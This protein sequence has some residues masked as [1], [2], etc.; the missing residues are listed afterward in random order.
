LVLEI[1]VRARTRELKHLN[2]TLEEKVVARTNDLAAKIKDMEKFQRL[3]IGRELKMIELKNEIN[4]L[5]A[6]IAQMESTQN[7]NNGKNIQ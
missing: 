2:Q 5:K 4:R 6:I 7:Q 1:R 3:T